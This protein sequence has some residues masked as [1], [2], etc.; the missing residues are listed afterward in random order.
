M[1]ES[2][3]CLPETITTLLIYYT[4][5]QN[6]KLKKKKKETTCQRSK[7]RF[8]RWSGKIPHAAEQ[9]SPYITTIES[10]CCDY[11][12]QHT[13]SLC[14]ATRGATAT[15]SLHT[16]AR[17]RLLLSTTRKAREQQRRPSTTKKTKDPFS[18]NFQRY[19]IELLTKV[20]MHELHPYDF[21][22]S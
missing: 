17:A 12:G 14:S 7:H 10:A 21:F 20:T 15:G 3:C 13:Y 1:T 18:S 6:K 9:L 8:Y 5:L 2:L 11:R 22:I 4:P 16:K 19:T